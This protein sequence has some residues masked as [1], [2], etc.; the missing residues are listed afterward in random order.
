MC[1][2][3]RPREVLYPLLPLPAERC[4]DCC[5]SCERV[6][7]QL[8]G[9]SV[10]GGWTS[11]VAPLWH[12]TTEPTPA[13]SLLHVTLVLLDRR[14]LPSTR[15]FVLVVCAPE[16]PRFGVSALVS[17]GESVCVCLMA[18]VSLMRV[19]ICR[20]ALHF[21]AHL[22]LL[23]FAAL[24]WG[25]L[26]MKRR[27]PA[28]APQAGNTPTPPHHLVMWARLVRPGFKHPACFAV[29]AVVYWWSLQGG[30]HRAQ[31]PAH[32]RFRRPRLGCGLVLCV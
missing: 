2:V 28:P 16:L 19:L 7:L 20:R 10:V 13:C 9:E 23:C 22:A 15:V 25:R 11:V 3:L 18:C 21:G 32:L 31:Q 29:L 4:S 8:F 14:C 12:K 1:V 5:V 27:V 26:R 30:Q 17:S 24:H 6:C